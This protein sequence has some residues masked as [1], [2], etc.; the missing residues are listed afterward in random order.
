MEFI[1]PEK[2][3][4]IIKVLGVGG[5]GGNAVNHMYRQGIEGVDFIIFNSDNQALDS[6]PVPN[7][8]QIGE[9]LTEGLGAG[10]DPETGKKAAVESLED[11]RYVLEDN[12]KMIFITAGMGGGTGTGA[13]PVI[14]KTAKE[15][16]I[17]TVGIVTT[18][19]HFEGHTR[20]QQAQEGIEKMKQCVDSLIVINNEKL[21]AIYNTMSLNEAFAQADNILAT[22]AKGIADIINYKGYINVDFM[23]VRTVMA[24]SG[25]A[26]MGTSV[27]EGDDRAVKAAAQ[28]LQSPLLADNDIKGSAS[29][30][31]HITYG[32]QEI[33]MDEI[34]QITDYIKQES[35]GGSNMIFGAAYDE[36]LSDSICVT[37]VAT[38]FESKPPE[39]VPNGKVEPDFTIENTVDSGSLI[40]EIDEPE[41]DKIITPEPPKPEEPEEGFDFDQ[42]TIDNRVSEEIDPN[43]SILNVNGNGQTIKKEVNYLELEKLPAYLRRKKK[44]EAVS[45]SSSRKVSKLSMAIDEH[46]KP[47]IRPNNRYL[48]D[49]VD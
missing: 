35:G 26:L 39:E 27:A 19:F 18:P 13:A 4:N 23:D 30:L 8:Y 28:V 33:R 47:Q 29:I 49:N 1:R 7:K 14:A 25:V 37:L 20:M 24:N 43:I 45:H 34:S 5:G 9:N 2:Q 31:L 41:P 15:L 3:S 6:S 42:I 10:A 40:T 44:L 38:G 48:N 11:I 22:A 21:R 32:K 16:D 17:L 46:K 12:T 36:S